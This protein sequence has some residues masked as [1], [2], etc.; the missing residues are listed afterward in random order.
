MEWRMAAECSHS[1]W[2]LYMSS[3]IEGILICGLEAGECPMPVLG[4]TPSSIKRSC[5][6]RWRP[7]GPYH[8]GHRDQKESYIKNRLLTF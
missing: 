2:G 5:Q 1:A 8:L 3:G 7:P 4:P 6:A